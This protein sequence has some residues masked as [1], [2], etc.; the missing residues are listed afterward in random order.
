LEL[1][2][3]PTSVT[4]GSTT[5]RLD[6]WDERNR[7]VAKGARNLLEGARALPQIGGIERRT[8]A[9]DK[10]VGQFDALYRQNCAVA[11]RVM[12]AIGDSV[13]QET[14]EEAGNLWANLRA[15][16]DNGGSDEDMALFR[17]SEELK[18]GIIEAVG[19]GSWSTIASSHGFISYG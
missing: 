18:N 7:S 6:E 9:Y 13:L 8:E 17:A 4:V 15:R 14:P 16:N 1:R 5:L 19:R 11:L 12:H 3:R 2:L 10:L